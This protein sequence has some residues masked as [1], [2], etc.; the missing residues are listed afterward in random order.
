MLSLDKPEDWP[1]SKS[2]V[3]ASTPLHYGEWG[4]PAVRTVWFLVG[5][6]PPI[7]FVTGLMMWW[8]PYAAQ[9]KASRIAAARGQW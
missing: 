2:I 8:A 1:L 6:L 5:L 9:R 7:L 4:G 3:Q